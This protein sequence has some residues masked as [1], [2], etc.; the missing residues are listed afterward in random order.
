FSE[1]FAI[2]PSSPYFLTLGDGFTRPPTASGAAV[3][4]VKGR[5]PAPVSYR[6]PSNIR[7]QAACICSHLSSSRGLIWHAG[8]ILARQSLFSPFNLA[9]SASKVEISASLASQ[10]ALSCCS[11]AV[12]AATSD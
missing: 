4:P 2:I 8:G 12:Q 10:S 6:L 5:L 7:P 11:F 1:Y 3:S 9:K